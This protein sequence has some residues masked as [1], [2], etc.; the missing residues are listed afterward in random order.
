MVSVVPTAWA[1]LYLAANSLCM[2]TLNLLGT[3]RDCLPPGVVTA[4]GASPQAVIATR[5]SLYLWFHSVQLPSTSRAAGAMSGLS[6]S[7][8]SILQSKFLVSSPTYSKLITVEHS[9][10]GAHT[11]G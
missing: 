4:M 11:A 1:D 10:S 2:H 7:I 5:I 3:A 8:S 9:E 6:V